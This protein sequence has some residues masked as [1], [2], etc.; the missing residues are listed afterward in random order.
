MARKAKFFSPD[1]IKTRICQAVSCDMQELQQV[2]KL[3]HDSAI[4]L[5]SRLVSEIDKKYTSGSQDPKLRAAKA[6]QKFRDVNKHMEKYNLEGLCLPGFS[7]ERPQSRYTAR[8]N[9][10]LRA[11]AICHFVL[12][13]F[14]EDEWFR[15]CKHGTGSSIGV[16]FV[17][18]TVEAKFTL[19]ITC[20]R[21]VSNLLKVYLNFDSSLKSSVAYYN[22][23]TPFGDW[24][25]IVDGS[26]A[27]VVPKT[28]DVDRMI[29]VEP[30][31][32]MFFQ[33]GLMA[34]MY[35]RFKNVGLDLETLPTCHRKRALE[36][37]ITSSEA[38]I[39]WSS[40]SDTIS[41]DL[42]RWLIPPIWFECCDMVR[43]PFLEI[44]GENIELSMF[45]TMGNAVTFPLETLVF[46]SLGQA[47]LID[48]AGTLSHFP[49]WKDRH[50]MSVFGDD[51]ILP[52]DCALEFIQLMQSVGCI[53]NI[54]KSYYDDSGFRE[55]CGG[56]YLRGWD[57]RPFYLKA[58]TSKSLSALEPWLYII[59]NRLLPKYIS[60]FGERNYVYAASG[61]MS[62]IASL[63]REYHLDLKVVPP[64]YP[65]DSGWRMSNDIGRLLICYPFSL[66]RVSV[67]QNGLV[68][69]RFLRYRYREQKPARKCGDIR[70]AIWLK[71]SSSLAAPEVTRA[72]QI[73]A[74]RYLKKHSFSRVI[75]MLESDDPR[76]DLKSPFR[77]RRVN[78]GYT[79]A[80]GETAHWTVVYLS[81]R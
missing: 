39:D 76:A 9:I 2:Y 22:N 5:G 47:L 14:S 11:R 42:L 10:L 77:R 43:S 60:C 6:Y 51:C 62:T 65:D 29:A 32:N 3:P 26:R 36:S 78:G 4:T 81:S 70:Y 7:M 55:S 21:R 16:P 45:S 56:D 28:N 49:E 25:N 1:V 61:L 58:P 75:E 50:K 69:F 23:S 38:T 30:T 41:Y 72:D 33:Q 73:E 44:E 12:S 24:Y 67:S 27:T 74:C 52:S 63:F 35:Q 34:M 17:D 80:R 18:T 64:D 46:W 71:K 20:T 79:V 19:P 8:E 48:K 53:V 59:L 15:N 13:P 31:G 66:S 54:E 37:S 68:S 57:V 40:A